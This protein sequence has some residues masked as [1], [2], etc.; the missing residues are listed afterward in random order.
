[1]KIEILKELISI[2][3][4]LDAKGFQKEA[5]V[6]DRIIKRAEETR[7]TADSGEAREAYLAA[8]RAMMEEQPT[9]FDGAVILIRKLLNEIVQNPG[10]LGYSELPGAPDSVD[11]SN[12]TWLGNSDLQKAWEAFFAALGEPE[13]GRNWR[14]MG[15]RTGTGYPGNIFGAVKYIQDIMKKEDNSSSTGS[16]AMATETMAREKIAYDNLLGAWKSREENDLWERYLNTGEQ[17]MRVNHEAAARY[18][19]KYDKEMPWQEALA[20]AFPSAGI[21]EASAQAKVAPERGIVGSVDQADSN[22]SA[23][24]DPYSFKWNGEGNDTYT[25]V[26]VN[27]DMKG[28]RE[29]YGRVIRNLNLPTDTDEQ[30]EEAKKSAWHILTKR[31]LGGN[32]IWD[33]EVAADTDANE[34]PPAD[35]GDSGQGVARAQPTEENTNATEGDEPANSNPT[36]PQDYEIGPE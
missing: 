5:S 19:A 29:A 3:N 26:A 13:M 24:G 12:S 28:K 31:R 4:S 35:E 22:L 33:Q 20:Q 10:E 34:T 23:P 9:S 32:W 27:L 2:A 15:P 11:T 1:M 6:V 17:T 25:V 18:A 16:G 30:K 8:R 36:T 14:E 7:E 21:E